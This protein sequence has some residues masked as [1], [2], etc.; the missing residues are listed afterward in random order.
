MTDVVE[1]YREYAPLCD[2][3]RTVQALLETVPDEHL[4]GLWRVVLTNSG[5]LQ[6]KRRKGWSWARGRKVR[7]AKDA[8]GL[9]HQAW[10]GE[11]AWIEVF[12]DKALLG[13]PAWALRL[14]MVREVLL[15]GVLY[16][17]LG[18][19]LHKVQRPEHREREAVADQWSRRL[20]REHM[21]QRHWLATMLLRP[22]S[23]VVALE[24]TLRRRLGSN[25]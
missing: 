10:K 24:R 2:A 21:R 25:K 11:R 14:A 4:Q 22:I 9:Y 20:L 8:A 18:H 15:G 7:H 1:A 19:H 17:E 3:A 13:C 23:S 12:V 16:H 5:A 6:G